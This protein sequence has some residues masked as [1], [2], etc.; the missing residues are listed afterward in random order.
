[1][2]MREK[3]TCAI[4][5]FVLLNLYHMNK[6]NCIITRMRLTWYF[7]PTRKNFKS[8]FDCVATQSETS[9]VGFV[10]ENVTCKHDIATML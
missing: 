9:V 1:M 2:L 3:K 4:P 10:R 5:I 8:I 6:A 7:K